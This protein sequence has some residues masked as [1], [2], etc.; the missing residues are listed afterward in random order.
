MPASSG[1]IG[2]DQI[3]DPSMWPTLFDNV[4]KLIE[5]L[6]KSQDKIKENLI[7]MRSILSQ[8]LTNTETIAELQKANAKIREQDEALK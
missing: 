6:D 3:I 2:A 8:K 7:A 1:K 5:L 4:N